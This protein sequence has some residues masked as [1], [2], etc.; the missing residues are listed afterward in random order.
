MPG[1]ALLQ[2]SSCPAKGHEAWG[3][4]PAESQG[5]RPLDKPATGFP[6]WGTPLRGK[7]LF[8]L[9]CL[10]AIGCFLPGSQ[11]EVDTANP[12]RLEQKKNVG[13]NWQ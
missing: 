11:N 8:V 4:N 3:S 6:P 1:S 13:G 5:E 2:E 7:L 12:R 10:E 9:L